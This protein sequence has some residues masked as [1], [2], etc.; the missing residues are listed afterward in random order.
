MPF[1]SHPRKILV[2]CAKRKR[3]SSSKN[4]SPLHELKMLQKRDFFSDLFS[5]SSAVLRQNKQKT[6]R[7]KKKFNEEKL[8]TVNCMKL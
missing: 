6:Q 2:K 4:N 8:I 1:D 5:S 3:K 7:G